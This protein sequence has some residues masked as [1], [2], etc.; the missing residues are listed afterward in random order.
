MYSAFFS[1]VKDDLY[2]PDAIGDPRVLALT[3]M[4]R[5][6]GDP[7]IDPR[8][9]APARVTLRLK[10]GR[11]V[12][13]SSATIKGSPEEPMSDIELEEKLRGCLA[14]GLGASTAQA[15]RLVEAVRALEH[16]PDAPHALLDAFPVPQDF[17]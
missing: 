11:D 10:N 5:V 2:E 4:T 15:S 13:A 16:A 3:A 1:R 17:Q 6:V 14:F 7:A 9:I 12:E 8:A